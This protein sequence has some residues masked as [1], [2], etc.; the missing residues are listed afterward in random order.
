MQTWRLA[1]DKFHDIA[2]AQ[3]RERDASIAEP[4]FEKVVDEWSVVGD[5]RI[6]ESARFAQIL[7]IGLCAALN[8]GRSTR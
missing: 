1:L 7:L 4:V 5:C 6:G 3:P 2:G 8:G